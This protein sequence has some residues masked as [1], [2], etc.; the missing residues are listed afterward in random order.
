M[1]RGAG[2]GEECGT[3]RAPPKAAWARAL[4]W[5]VLWVRAGALWPCMPWLCEPP[6]PP[7]PRCWAMTGTAVEATAIKAAAVSRAV[8][9]VLK[10]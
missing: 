10:V 1:A 7:P 9:R 4:S 3:A 6:P 8:V 2:A 5:G